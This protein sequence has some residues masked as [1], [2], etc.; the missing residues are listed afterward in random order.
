MRTFASLLDSMQLR[1]V[2]GKLEGVQ[3]QVHNFDTKKT[4]EKKKISD[5]N[6]VYFITTLT[7]YLFLGR[8]DVGAVLVETALVSPH[9]DILPH[10]GPG[11]SAHYRSNNAQS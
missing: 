3:I 4:L 2:L 9:P 6:D 8:I 5:P 7:I 10:T 11:V 1:K